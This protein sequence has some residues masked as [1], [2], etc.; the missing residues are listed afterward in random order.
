MPL[1]IGQNL[2]SVF[3]AEVKT[4]NPIFFVAKNNQNFTHLDTLI[5]DQTHLVKH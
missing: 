3:D 5:P 2:I 4:Q 1:I